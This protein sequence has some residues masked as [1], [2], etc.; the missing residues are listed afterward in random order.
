MNILHVSL[1]TS[2]VAVLTACSSGGGSSSHS[3]SSTGNT[4]QIPTSLVETAPPAE[5]AQPTETTPTPPSSATA[6][7]QGLLVPQVSN[8]FTANEVTGTSHTEANKLTIDGV[9]LALTPATF[10]GLSSNSNISAGSY[11]KGNVGVLYT[12]LENVKYGVTGSLSGYDNLFIIGKPTQEMPTSG[13]ATYN[14]LALIYSKKLAG[15]DANWT[16]NFKVDFASKKLEGSLVDSKNETGL[17]LKA[18]IEGNKFKGTHNGNYTEGGF[19]GK[20]ASELSGVLSSEID[21]FT[22]VYGAKKSN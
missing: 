14:G 19:F 1:L 9:E 3:S 12:H 11:V 17:T 22:G 5:T 20:D 13:E 8:I 10:T 7:Y 4:T 6:E 18:D 2:F 21:Q 15:T 16:S